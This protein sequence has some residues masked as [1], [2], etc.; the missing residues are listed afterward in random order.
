M[1]TH[2]QQVYRVRKSPY[3]STVNNILNLHLGEDRRV[4]WKGLFSI[5]FL[6]P[7]VFNEFFVQQQKK[8]GSIH[9]LSLGSICENCPKSVMQVGMKNGFI[10]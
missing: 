7:V 5:L 3:N 8:H 9:S 10:L 2:W 6:N 1:L 4:R